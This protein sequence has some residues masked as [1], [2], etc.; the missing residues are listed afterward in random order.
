M[1]NEDPTLSQVVASLSL[2]TDV[3]MGHPFEQGLGTCILATRLGE[4]AGLPEDALRQSYDLALLRHIGCTTE[5][6][7]LAA[8]VG[9]E[10]ALSAELAPMSGAKASEYV[11]GFIRFVTAGRPP[12]ARVRAMAKLANGL[13]GF[14]AAQRAICEVAQFLATRLGF[15]EA[16]VAALGTVYE[17]WDGKGMPNKLRAD[18]VP[19]P[20]RLS[21]VADLAAVLHDLGRQDALAV[22]RARSGSGFDPEIVQLFVKHADEL[23]DLLDVP[24]R[25]EAVMGAEPG[26][27]RGLDGPQLDEA[28]GAAADFADLKSPFLVGHS[29]GVAELAAAAA[30][31]LRLPATDVDAVRRAGLVHD[32]GRVGVSAA[33]WGKTSPLTSADWEAIRL[34]PYQTERILS[35][36]PFLSRLSEIASFHHERPDGS[37]YFRGARGAQLGPAATVLAA[38]DAYHAMR[39]PRPHRPART[40][41]TAAKELRGMVRAGH[42][43]GPSAEAVLEAAGHRLG[44]RR[45]QPGGLTARE[46]EVLRLVARGLSTREVAHALVIAPKTADNHIQSI[47]SKAGVSTRAAATVFAMQH[48]LLDPLGDPTV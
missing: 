28:L 39:E 34:H 20:V 42:V 10:V 11:G 47:Y 45:Q 17:R 38:A 14:N 37:G 13:R 25:W 21:Q 12:A 33:I 32:L 43:D 26:G 4:L 48:G 22:L 15:D 19:L 18:A 31:R 8:A 40:P 44:R 35:R 9:D 29:S 46:V 2:A 1:A 23:F 30:E 36:A 27:P 3:A 24:S 41:D 7:G 16:L 5:T 6:H